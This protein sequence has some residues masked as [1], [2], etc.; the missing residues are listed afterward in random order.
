MLTYVGLMGLLSSPNAA[1]GA[2]DEMPEVLDLTGIVRDFRERATGAWF[3][4]LRR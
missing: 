4:P 3:R 1:S 2:D